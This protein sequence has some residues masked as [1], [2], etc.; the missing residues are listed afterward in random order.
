MGDEF[1]RFSKEY[2]LFCH[3]T[4]HVKGRK[5]DGLL[6]EKGG[7]GFPHLVAMDSEG[8][9][10]AVHDG[11]RTAQ[12]FAATMAVA[13]EFVELKKK[14][15]AGDKEAKYRVLVHGI[16]MGSLSPLEAEKSVNEL[17]PL[18]KERQEELSGLLADLAVRDVL[19]GVGP[20]PTSQLEAG[21]KF[22]EM[23]R[24]G[25]PPPSGDGEVQAYW[26]LMMRHAESRKDAAIFEEALNAL[27]ARFGGVPQ[28]QQFFKTQE[29]KLRKLK[30][31]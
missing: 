16:K 17:G 23:K 3:V 27:K 10:L 2:V 20:D 28:A 15:A 12:G 13:K 7:R 5:Y 8:N 9:V 18:A 4:S 6:S 25:K 26:I 31:K 29:E 14:A 30:E 22:M 21:R 19:K 11:P 24:A 1:V